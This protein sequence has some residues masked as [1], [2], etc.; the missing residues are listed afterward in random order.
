MHTTMPMVCIWRF[1]HYPIIIPIALDAVFGVDMLIDA[2]LFHILRSP[3]ARKLR[4]LKVVPSM[5]T[6]RGGDSDISGQ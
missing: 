3:L 1:R 2:I 4:L 5:V 6:R